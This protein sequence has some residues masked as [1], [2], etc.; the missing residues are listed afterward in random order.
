MMHMRMWEQKNVE[1]KKVLSSSSSATTSKGLE[2]TPASEMAMRSVAV[3]AT[4]RQL[5]FR[6][7]SPAM[8][9]C[10]AAGWPGHSR[11]LRAL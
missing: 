9:L 2:A 10:D 11:G 6:R 3:T 4:T 8:D 5:W 1:M 7:V